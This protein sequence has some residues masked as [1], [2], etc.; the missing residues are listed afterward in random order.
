VDK[1]SAGQGTPDAGDVPPAKGVAGGGLGE[2]RAG[3]RGHEQEEGEVVDQEAEEE[4]GRESDSVAAELQGEEM[5]QGS[6]GLLGAADGFREGGIVGDRVAELAEQRDQL[7][8][9]CRMAGKETR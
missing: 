1:H 6:A 8:P 9:A 2:P 5:M 3:E 7:R 4:G